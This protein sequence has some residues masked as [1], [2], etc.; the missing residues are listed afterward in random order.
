[1]TCD[2][3]GCSEL[4]PCLD[5]RTGGPCS[6]AAPGLCSA[7]VDDDVEQLQAS[8]EPEPPAAPLLYDA[9]GGVL[10]R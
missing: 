9:Y 3:C 10:V 8:A 6:W 5:E 2:G 7:C 4:D 1:M